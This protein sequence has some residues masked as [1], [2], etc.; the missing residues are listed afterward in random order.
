VK[1]GAPTPEKITDPVILARVVELMLSGPKVEAS[2]R[3]D[4]L[5]PG[6][7]KVS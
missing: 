5:D 4:R 2:S 1:S 6:R 7:K 3:G